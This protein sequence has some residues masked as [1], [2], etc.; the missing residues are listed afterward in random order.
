M[1]IFWLMACSTQTLDEECSPLYYENFGAAF[2]TENCQG[3]HAQEARDREGAPSAVFF[4]TKADVLSQLDVMI[5]E[6]EMQTM[7]PAGGLSEEELSAALEWLNCME[8][9]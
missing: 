5:A 1:M 4:D 2:L 7:P 3:C 9:Q 8:L 6:I